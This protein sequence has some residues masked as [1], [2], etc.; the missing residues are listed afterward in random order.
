MSKAKS[1]KSLDTW[2]KE[3]WGTK[4]GKNSTSGNPASG[5]RVKH[6]CSPKHTKQKMEATKTNV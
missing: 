6:R 1:Q 3:D 5:L 4:S 2:T